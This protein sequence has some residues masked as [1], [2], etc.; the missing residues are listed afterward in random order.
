MSSEIVTNLEKHRSL[1]WQ[2]GAGIFYTIFAFTTFFGAI[3]TLFLRE[4][5]LDMTRIGIIQ[6]LLPFCGLS[7]LFVGPLIQRMGYKRSFLMFY[8]A[9]TVVALGLLLT[10]GL[11]AWQGIKFTFGW[12]AFI[13]LAFALFRSVAETAGLSWGKDIIP[14]RIR[15]KFTAISS[16][17]NNLVVVLS[18]A[19]A[20]YIIYRGTGL[21]RFMYIMGGGVFIGA[22]G[23]FCSGQV[24]GGAAV[25]REHHLPVWTTLREPL[26]NRQ[27]LRLL[28][29]WGLVT[30]AVTSLALNPLFFK[31]KVGIDTAKV[32][33][34]DMAFYT[35]ATL[36]SFLWGWAAD[37]F[38]GK[39]TMLTG[40]SAFILLPFF[41]LLIPRHHEYSL[42]IG[43]GVQGFSG[44]M[45]TGWAVAAG[46]YLFNNAVPEDARKNGY[47]ILYYAVMGL[48]GGVGPLTAG[49]LLDALAGVNTRFGGIVIDQFSIL[50]LYI[51][52][53]LVISLVLLRELRG[54]GS[55]KVRQFVGMFIQG[56]PI[57]T[58]S[59]MIRYRM[60]PDESGRVSLTEKLGKLSSPLS[61]NELLEA[62]HDPSF[63]VRYEAII[64]L[65]RMKS[66]PEVLDGLLEIL[67]GNDAE[68]SLAA[69]WAL[70]RLGDQSAIL[71]LRETLLSEYP[72]LRARSARALATL[73]DYDSGG[74][75]LEK[76]QSE[77]LDEVRVACASALG[78]LRVTEAL[79]PI[80]AYLYANKNTSLRSE[81]TLAAARIVGDEKK[82]IRLRQ[83]IRDDA[84]TG[85]AQGILSISKAN[86]RQN[87][88]DNRFQQVAEE[89]ADKFSRGEAAVGAEK[90]IELIELAPSNLLSDTVL[91]VLDEC[92]ERL[93]EFGGAREEYILL[94]IHVLM[95]GIQDG[96]KKV[97]IQNK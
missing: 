1:K 15:G 75:M 25:A 62:M 78:R 61:T 49:L 33:W 74:F 35:G 81:L 60:A 28:A 58:L 23:L 96:G 27:F 45:I 18:M 5:E 63:N 68:L 41:L 13:V 70:G 10:P 77:S 39:P 83:S 72:L 79:K 73:G 92:R 65:A 54:G 36:S 29:G 37:R 89:C 57:Q 19:G 9:R 7:A 97:R 17:L 55:M 52:V 80:L 12:L 67:G 59:L 95:S 76:F 48:S 86:Q 4:L 66:T 8:G 21:S 47:M 69:A 3:F 90:L 16:A 38:G 32:L 2:L 84:E 6:S 46:T 30:L 56:N 94:S 44:I 71:G 87:H 51:S 64:S 43:V 26:K 14:D 42:W 91:L 31:E 53:L 11:L 20:S 50:F 85:I 34:L 82:Y 40:L 93:R 88:T 24:P 22:L